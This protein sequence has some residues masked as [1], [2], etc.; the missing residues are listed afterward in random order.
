[1]NSIGIRFIWALCRYA[2]LF[3]YL[4]KYGTFIILRFF[5]LI[6]DFVILLN[7]CNLSWEESVHF[8]Y[9]FF[10]I[11]C[12][13]KSCR[14]H[15]FFFEKTKQWWVAFYHISTYHQLARHSDL[16]ILKIILCSLS[17]ETI[18]ICLFNKYLFPWICL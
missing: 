10:S 13:N 12:I 16:F 5:S 8:P 17:N 4:D 18:Y 14:S 7:W 15:F 9:D 6:E 11:N 1:M 3:I 2:N